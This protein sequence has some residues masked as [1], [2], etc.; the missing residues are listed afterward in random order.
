M[1]VYAE[2]V[3]AGFAASFA[4]DTKD[5]IMTKG[6]DH[7][8]E[9]L[10]LLEARYGSNRPTAPESWNA[11]LSLLLSHRSVRSYLPTP[12][13]SG[14]LELIISAAQSAST[15]SNLQVWSVV[16]V[17]EPVRKARLAALAGN[18]KHI[19]QAPL[20]LVFLAD[21]SRL[22]RI[23]ERRGVHSE[24]HD[25]IES[26]LTGVIDAALA[27][28]NAVTAAE[29]IGLGSVYIGAIRNN[30]EAVAAELGLPPNVLAVFG[31]VLGF[32]DPATQSAVKPRLPQSIILHKE[33]YNLEI[34]PGIIETYD[35]D[36][37]RFQKSQGIPEADWSATSVERVATAAA[38]KG[39]SRL[40]E[41]LRK[42][43]F[44]LK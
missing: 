26:L 13:P 28:Q 15:S 43:G 23:A 32:P 35:Q 33:R 42:L 7:F 24:A 21:L 19:E 22:D 6:G 37:R 31:L 2:L 41:A 38:L 12:L 18:Q 4:I 44:G 40:S 39:R 14:T 30:P 16:A 3:S 11:T 17:E 25:Y 27:A 8:P 10:D 36:L 1:A 29:S 9:V 34:Q 20:L 5:K